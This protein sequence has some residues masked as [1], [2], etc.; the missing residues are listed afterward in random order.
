MIPHFVLGRVKFECEMV[1]FA[2]FAV[3]SLEISSNV[4]ML[5]TQDIDV[6]FGECVAMNVASIALD[7]HQVG[8]VIRTV[9]ADVGNGQLCVVVADHHLRREAAL[10]RQMHF[11]TIAK[12]K[13]LLPESHLLR[14]KSEE[15]PTCIKFRRQKTK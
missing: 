6:T 5:L 8:G 13:Q 4:A 3:R 1:I 14:L 11:V 12:S 7:D 15:W 9:L 10:C 2:V